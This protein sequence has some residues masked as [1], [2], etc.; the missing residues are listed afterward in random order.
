V[1]RGEA[2]FSNVG[3]GNGR[4]CRQKK[5][6]SKGRALHKFKLKNGQARR[7]KRGPLRKHGPRREILEGHG[8]RVMGTI[9]EQ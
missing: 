2:R 8:K 9:S 5:R 1:K 7:D 6:V 4:R 3:E